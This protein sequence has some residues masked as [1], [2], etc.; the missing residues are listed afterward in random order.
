MDKIK[1]RI[2]SNM[3]KICKEKLNEGQGPAVKTG[4]QNLLIG[5]KISV[6]YLM[7]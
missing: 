7:L 2:I 1:G 5:Y 3:L 6:V 4:G